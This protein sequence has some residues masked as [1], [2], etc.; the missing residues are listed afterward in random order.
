MDQVSS[1]REKIGVRNAILQFSVDRSP[2]DRDGPFKQ[3][4]QFRVASPQD[5]PALLTT[6]RVGPVTLPKD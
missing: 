3:V 6:A 5:I 1:L 4:L 2:V